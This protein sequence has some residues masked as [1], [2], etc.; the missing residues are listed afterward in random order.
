M[1]AL[2]FS[3]LVINVIIK[4]VDRYVYM[5]GNLCLDKMYATRNTMASCPNLH[6]A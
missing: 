5:W 2:I 3:R 1:V 4:I 6:I